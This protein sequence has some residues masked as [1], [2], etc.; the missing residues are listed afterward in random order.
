MSGQTE[1]KFM[2]LA[3]L[4]IGE[5]MLNDG[6]DLLVAELD[7]DNFD[8]EE[9]AHA[10]GYAMAAGPDTLAALKGSIDAYVQLINSGDAGRWDPETDDH[11]IAGRAAIAKAEGR[12]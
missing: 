11:V 5:I 1:R 7:M 2:P 8:N 6:S 3:Y 9:D 10:Y 12:A 4:D